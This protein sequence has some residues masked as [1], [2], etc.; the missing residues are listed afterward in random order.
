ME[1]IFEGKN[2]IFD[3]N[4]IYSVIILLLLT[5]Y[6]FISFQRIHFGVK[7]LQNKVSQVS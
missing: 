1:R 2:L 6:F 4:L 7:R 3:Q 5:L